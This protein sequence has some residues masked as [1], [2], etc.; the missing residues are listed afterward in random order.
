MVTTAFIAGPLQLGSRGPRVITLQSQLNVALSL[1]PPLAADGI[2]GVLTGD[3]VRR[4]QQRCG[5]RVD[6]VVGP[7]S[8]AALGLGYSV[9]PVP[10]PMPGIFSPPSPPIPGGAAP[11]A[12]SGQGAPLDPRLLAEIADAVVRGLANI[13]GAASRIMG[14][15]ASFP[16]VALATTRAVVASAVRSAA[17]ILHG[18]PAAVMSATADSISFIQSQIHAAINGFASRVAGVLGSVAGSP[19]VAAIIEVWARASRLLLRVAESVSTLLRRG[20]RAIGAI[21]SVVAQAVQ[22]AVHELA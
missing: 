19:G 21:A 5:L 16:D 1:R 9:A 20:V 13:A 14:A 4:L 11:V 8:A 2:F 6:G 12:V 3:A 18:I 15:I 22:A 17:A 7:A 10:P